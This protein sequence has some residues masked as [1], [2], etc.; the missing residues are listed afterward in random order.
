[1]FD[2]QVTYTVDKDYCGNNP[3]Q[4]HYSL[5]GKVPLNG[6]IVYHDDVIISALTLDSVGTSTVAL[7]G[8][9]DGTLRKV[10]RS[11]RLPANG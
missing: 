5:V 6:T 4:G 11:R 10:R 3:N 9:T 8:M 1:M 2:L 7:L